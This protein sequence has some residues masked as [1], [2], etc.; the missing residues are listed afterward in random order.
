V[1]IAERRCNERNGGKKMSGQYYQ[2]QPQGQQPYPPQPYPAEKKGL[3]TFF[4]AKDKI[5]LFLFLCAGLVIIGMLL[6]D[7]MASSLVDPDEAIW[8]LGML[9]VDV[10]IVAT[11]TLVLVGGICRDDLPEKTRNGMIMAAAIITVVFVIVYMS[12]ATFS[13]F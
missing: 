8:F 9:A 6:L 12:R 4:I 10:G 13:F 7:L 1:T 11:I 2:Q 5:G 3:E